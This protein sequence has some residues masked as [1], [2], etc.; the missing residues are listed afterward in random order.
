MT[1]EEFAAL[2]AGDLPRW[3]RVINALGIKGE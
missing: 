2:A 1:R 3:A